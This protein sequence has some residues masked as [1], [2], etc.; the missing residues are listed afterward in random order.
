MDLYQ[1]KTSPE[2]ALGAGEK[3]MVIFIL[4]DNF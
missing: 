3:S 4:N 2:L 1:Q